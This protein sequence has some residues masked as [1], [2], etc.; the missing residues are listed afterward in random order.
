M[1][2]VHTDDGARKWFANT[3][4]ANQYS[5]MLSVTCTE[6]MHA[7]WTPLMHIVVVVNHH[8]QQQQQQQQPSC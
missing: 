2:H 7:Q 5:F 8:Q 4:G 6:Q 3:R 1:M